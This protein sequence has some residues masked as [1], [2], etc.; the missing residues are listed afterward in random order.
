MQLL[1]LTGLLFAVLLPLHCLSCSL[2]SWLVDL[3]LLA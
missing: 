3:D 2:H 1:T